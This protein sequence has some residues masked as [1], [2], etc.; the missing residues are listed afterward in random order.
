M[1]VRII[2]RVHIENETKYG[3]TR[4]HVFSNPWHKYTLNF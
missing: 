1:Q 2:I 3:L 4:T